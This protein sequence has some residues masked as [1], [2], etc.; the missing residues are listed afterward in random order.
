MNEI[1]NKLAEYEKL[2]V[3]PSADN[4]ENLN[5]LFSDSFMEVGSSGKIFNKEQTLYALASESIPQTDLFEFSL[6]NLE[7][8]TFLL[9]Y[10]ASRFAGGKT[11]LSYR[12]SIWQYK[13]GKWQILF[14]Q[15]TNIE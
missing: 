2:F 7:G 6:L 10:K 1:I 15:G 8:D 9:R 13:N 11:T 5:Q 3:N 4:A 14:H 12:S